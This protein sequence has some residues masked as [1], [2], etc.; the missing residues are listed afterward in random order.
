MVKYYGTK[1]TTALRREGKS[2]MTILYIPS[3][4][5]LDYKKYYNITLRRLEGDVTFSFTKKLTRVGQDAQRIIISS[6]YGIESG[7]MII[8]TIEEANS[9]FDDPMDINDT[10]S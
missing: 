1:R 6:K 5:G 2:C 9:E 4:W 3:D 8:F 10:D 7:E